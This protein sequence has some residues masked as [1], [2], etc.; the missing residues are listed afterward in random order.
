MVHRLDV[1]AGMLKKTV[2]RL[3]GA[4][5]K[6]KH[7]QRSKGTVKWPASCPMMWNSMQAGYILPRA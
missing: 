5:Y 7:G 4:C 6:G 2:D 3:D 1:N